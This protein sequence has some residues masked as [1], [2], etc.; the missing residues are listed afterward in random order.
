MSDLYFN[1]INKKNTNFLLMC[2]FIIIV[3]AV[4]VPFSTLMKQSRV[5]TVVTLGIFFKSIDF[6][7][8]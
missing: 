3:V 1:P 5:L 7:H 8:T 6:P 4:L 2:V